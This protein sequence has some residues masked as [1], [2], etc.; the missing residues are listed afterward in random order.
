MV[1]KCSNGVFEKQEN[2]EPIEST[3]G[4]PAKDPPKVKSVMK[5]SQIT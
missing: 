3:D 4:V 1:H 5:E 2:Q